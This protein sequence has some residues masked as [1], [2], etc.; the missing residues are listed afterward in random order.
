MAEI[1]D[2]HGMS[3]EKLDATN[4]E[5]KVKSYA[6]PEA[7]RFEIIGASSHPRVF[8]LEPGAILQIQDQGRTVKLFTAEHISPI[9]LFTPM[10]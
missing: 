6:I 9:N 1:I 2:V 8:T 7:T 10:H 3:G 5:G 4:D